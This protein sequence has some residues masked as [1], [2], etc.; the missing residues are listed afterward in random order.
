MNFTDF[1]PAWNAH[2]SVATEDILSCFLPLLRE[3]LCAHQLGL[4]APLEGIA[5][6]QVDH[7]RLWFEENRRIPPRTSHPQVSAIESKHDFAWDVVAESHRDLDV[8]T[9]QEKITHSEIVV[10]SDA[11]LA[12]GRGLRA[13]YCKNYVAWEHTLEHHDPLTDVFSLGMILAS[14]ALQLDFHDAEDLSQFV[15]NRRNLFAL[16]R[17]LHPVLAQAIGQMTELYRGSRSQDLHAILHCLENYR[18]QTVSLDVQLAL[19]RLS[20]SSEPKSRAS[21]I[22][23]RLRDRLFDLSRRNPLLNFRSTAQALNLTHASMPLSIHI[24]NIREDQLL[25]WNDELQSKIAKGTPIR[26]N[27]Y[28]NFN[29]A[30]YSASVLERLMADARRDKNEYGCSQLRLVVAF[31]GWSNLKEKPIESFVSPLVLLPVQINKQKGIRDTFTFEALD[32]QAEV[33][34]VIRHL[35][36]QLYGISLPESV[37]LNESSVNALFQLLQTQILANEPAI[38]LSKIERPRIEVIHEKAKRRLDQYRRSSRVAGKG[39]ARYENIDYSYDAINYHPLGIRLFTQR[40]RQPAFR[41][42]QIVSHELPIRN[43]VA[44]DP[45]SNCDDST[46][47][48]ERKL[49]VLQDT[50]IENPYQWTFDVCNL[51]LVNLHYRRMSLVRDYE[52]ILE[53]DLKNPAFDAAFTDT[54]RQVARQLPDAIPL[55]ERYEV[56][57]SDPTQSMAIAE[58]RT[59][60]SYIIQGPPGTGKSQTITNLIAD[61]VARGQRVL[62][63]CEKRA[64]IDVVY[65]RLKQSGL[66]SLC[67]LVHDSQADKKEFVLDLK[68]TYEAFTAPYDTNTKSTTKQKGMRAKV[69]SRLSDAIR[70]LER[71]ESAMETTLHSPDSELSV[72]MRELLDRCIANRQ[73]CPEMTVEELQGLPTLPQWW[74]LQPTL[75]RMQVHIDHLIPEKKLSHH[76]LRSLRGSLGLMEDSIDRVK[77]LTQQASDQLDQLERAIK[78]SGIPSDQWMTLDR[79]IQLLGYLDLVAPFANGDN[80]Q[81]LDPRSARTVLYRNG[82][83]KLEQLRSELELLRKQNHRWKKK[84]SAKETRNAIPQ[85]KAFLTS[86]T[87]WVSPAWW[88]LRSVLNTQYDFSNFSIRPTFVQILEELDREYLAEDVLQ[89]AMESLA[90]DLKLSCSVEEIQQALQAWEVQFPKLPPSIATIHRALMKSSKAPDIIHRSREVGLWM[91]GLRDTNEKLLEYWTHHSLE[92]LRLELQGIALHANEV[93]KVVDLLTRL[94]SLPPRLNRIMRTSSRSIPQLEAAIEAQAWRRWLQSEPDIERFNAREQA[95]YVQQLED[96]IDPWLKINAEEICKRTRERFL[97]RIQPN[98]KDPSLTKRCLQGR[99]ILEHEFGKTMRYRAIRDLVDGDSGLIVQDLKPVWLM[100]PLSVSD[101]LPLHTQFVDVVIFDEA[102]QVRLEESIPTLFRGTQTI[103]VGDTMQLPPTNFFSHGTAVEDLESNGDATDDSSPA[104]D[105]SSDS[106]LSHSG[107]YM[108]STM[109]GWHYR[110]RSESLINFSNWAFYDGR[111]LTVPDP[112]LAEVVEDVA[113]KETA[114]WTDELTV[115][116]KSPAYSIAATN[117]Q[118]CL[119]NWLK[120]PISYHFIKSGCYEERRNRPEAEHIAEL[121]ARWLEKESGQSLGIIAFSESQ[122]T[123]IEQALDERASYDEAFRARY[124]CELQREENGQFVGLLVK[125]LENIQGDERDIILL[126]VCYGPSR[127]GKI[128]MNFGPINRDGGEKRLNVAFSRAKQNMVVVSSMHYS[129]I[130]NDYNTGPNCLKQYLRYA[131]CMSNSDTQGAELALRQLSRW[132]A[133]GEERSTPIDPVT[134]EITEA[135]RSKGY[136]V[137]NQVGQSHFRIDAAVFKEGDERYRLG[138]IVDTV[139]SYRQSDPWERDVMRPRLLRDFGWK[140]HRVLGKDWYEDPASQLEQILFTLEKP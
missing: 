90:F 51:T 76:P 71:F 80:L 60:R 84:L 41:L 13:V 63:V 65:A 29:E 66:G 99:K 127:L 7:H 40:V 23:L 27:Q 53:R 79:I 131:E 88:R 123:E 15:T 110:S 102:S 122:Q 12:D 21:R 49:A 37:D 18:D 19:D 105:L 104:F 24:D 50:S 109:L 138:I 120:R 124:E 69:L 140:I 125:N 9:G 3:T 47:T 81:L 117:P 89:K 133:L 61:F 87:R 94:E 46:L 92:S 32:A 16:N 82:Q 111:L 121:V 45:A 11:L 14:L 134:H 75:Q 128:S 137:E 58:S 67:C 73:T 2:E 132:S 43:Y 139:A 126:S 85:A 17:S 98:A 44:P 8:D 68:T 54:P 6:L 57:A 74:Q 26:L 136:R 1:L 30:I 31:L 39:V 112:R 38:S 33:N 113:K 97:D 108:E 70:P 130:T 34:P 78:S 22:L 52:A 135:L 119:D 42:Q 96:T 4:V 25:V 86:L 5:D 101:T 114:T 35:F 106:L 56:V 95:S 20:A 48:V 62:F 72:S 107:K 116:E 77:Q 115:Q 103:I 118:P 64:A 10:E 83:A 28:I 55:Q 100:S 59:G 129:Q 93:P 36:R 91:N